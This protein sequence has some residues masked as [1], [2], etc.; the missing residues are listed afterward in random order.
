MKVIFGDHF[1][2]LQTVDGEHENSNDR[3]L[4]SALKPYLTKMKTYVQE[5]NLNQLCNVKDF[6]TMCQKVGL[7]LGDKLT[8]H[9]YRKYKTNNF[10]E[11]N[12]DV[13]S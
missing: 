1:K 11:L 7:N 4:S 6:T 2:T 12:L 13:F 3:L 8:D 10:D 9:F 5:E